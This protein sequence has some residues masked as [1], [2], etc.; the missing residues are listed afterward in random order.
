MVYTAEQQFISRA[1]KALEE[2][3]KQIEATANRLTKAVKVVR[4]S[5]EDV[6]TVVK[7]LEQEFS[8]ANQETE[9]LKSGLATAKND[10]IEL[11]N[12]AMH[13]QHDIEETRSM[14]P[15]PT[16]PYDDTEIKNQLEF[17][18]KELIDVF[19]RKH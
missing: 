15:E 3:Q 9:I 17:H 1:K 19:L 13:M 14:I 2:T 5:T 16:P 4:D 18:S 10:I 11:N 12:N 6:A 8:H 7:R